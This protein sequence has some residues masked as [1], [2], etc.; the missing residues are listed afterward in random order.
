MKTKQFMLGL[1]LSAMLGGGVAVGSYK[2]LEE[3]RP[4][5]G[6]QQP[7]TNVRYT[8]AMRASNVTV[9]EGINFVTAAE[10]V[11]PAV[12]HVTTEYRVQARRSP[13]E[14]HP[15]FRDFFGD[16]FEGYQRQQGPAMGSGSGVIIASNGY[17][18][19]NNHVIDRADK[20][21]VILDDKRTFDAT[22]VGTDPNT[23]IALLKINSENLPA[24]RYGN[25]DNVRVGEWVLAVGNP[26]NLNSTVTAGIVS[27]KGRNVGILQNA[28]SMSVESFIQTDAAVN[29]G[30]SGG[31]L[32]NLNGDLVGINTAI[33]SQ[34]GSFAGYSFAVP[35]SI[36]SKVVDDLLKYGEVQRALLG[37]SMQEVDAELAKEKG[38]K[39]LNGVYVAGFSES[40]AAKSAGLQEG[41]VIT[42]IN[43]VKV[44]TGAQLQEQVTRYRPG[45]KIKVGF[46]RGGNA[47][48][49]NVTLRNAN[50]STEIVKR[51]PN[52]AKSMTI[53]GATFEAASKQELSKLDITG[54]V[55][56]TGIEKSGFA[57]TGMKDNFIIT[58]IDRNSVN[59]PQDVEK[60]LKSSRGGGLLI[61]GVYPDGRRAYYAI[62]R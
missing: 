50:G 6:Q 22:L 53:E 48:T 45:D 11:T 61:E 24:L 9:P 20:I 7:N 62:G 57:E 42:E 40:S 44:N 13:S 51:D 18:V 37:V 46:V 2:L 25:S 1:M 3:D 43:G 56:V 41:D 33:A 49:I 29:P 36:V 14:I 19:T 60:I 12:V 10:L 16:D 15:F 34:T 59:T 17:I 32:V 27:A 58:R 21:K 55:K 35:S 31:A 26:F 30:N 28:G 52:A 4:A 47:K 54:G 38:I 5:A 23:D 39:N 8:S